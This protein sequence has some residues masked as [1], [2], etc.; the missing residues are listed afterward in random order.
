[1]EVDFGWIDTAWKI[2]TWFRKEQRKRRNIFIVKALTNPYKVPLGITLTD[3]LYDLRTIEGLL[4]VA[5]LAEAGCHTG[6][7]CYIE[8]MVDPQITAHYRPQLRTVARKY[9][10]PDIDDPQRL[11]KIEHILHDNDMLNW[12]PTRKGWS[13][14]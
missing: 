7:S 1:M 14:T 8:P 6:D 12:M 10:L 2:M 4:T 11:E 9:G 3:N 13:I 5:Q